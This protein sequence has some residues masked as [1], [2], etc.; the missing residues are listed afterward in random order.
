MAELLFEMD[1]TYYESCDNIDV[2]SECLLEF[3]SSAVNQLVFKKDISVNLKQPWYNK[4]LK[5]LKKDLKCSKKKFN[6][7]KNDTNWKL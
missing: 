5:D 2:K 3:L 4:E 7:Q 1:W 6:N